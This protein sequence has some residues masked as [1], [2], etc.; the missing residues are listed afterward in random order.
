MGRKIMR[1][2][3][4]AINDEG[5]WR[6]RT[7]AELQELYE[8]QDVVAFIKKGRL[9]WL[10]HVER[11]DNNRVPKRMLYG[12]PGEGRKT[13]NEVVRRYGEGL[14]RDRSEEMEDY[15]SG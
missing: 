4:D 11:M 14:E 6:I 10:G 1:K 15:G 3:Y 13:P 2:I 8:Q 5:Q 12:R 9:R 7:N